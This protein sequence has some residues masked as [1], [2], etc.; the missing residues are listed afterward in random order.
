MWALGPRQVTQLAVVVGRGHHDQP[1]QRSS[2]CWTPGPEPGAPTSP[3]ALA[4]RDLSAVF[5]RRPAWARLSAMTSAIVVGASVAGLLTARVLS[6]LVDEVVVVERERLDDTPAPRGH[7]PAG[8]APASAARPPVSTCWSPGSRASPTSSSGWARSASTARAPGSTR[9]AATAR[10]ATGGDRSQH[11]PAAARAGGSSP[12]RGAG[13]REARGRRRR[14]PGRRDR[15]TACP[16]V[17]VDGVVQRAD[18]V[19]DCSGRSSR[20][21]HQLESSGV[22]APPVTRV[23]IDCAYASG[24]LPRSADDFEGSFLVVRARPR[25]RRSA[26]GRSSRWRAIGGW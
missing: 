15:R 19:V 5:S 10:R 23:T 17:V 18:L 9:P 7:V 2:S 21:A 20:I 22:L 12:N 16:G 26:A 14:R 25:P 3:R 11:D 24:F 1:S 13:Q 4:S 6:D 8:P